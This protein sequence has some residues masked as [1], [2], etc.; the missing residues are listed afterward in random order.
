[1]PGNTTDKNRASYGQT[2]IIIPW[3]DFQSESKMLSLFYRIGL[4]GQYYVEDR[5][6]VCI[7]PI[8]IA[9]TKTSH[10]S[11]CTR[12]TKHH[13]ILGSSSLNCFSIRN[14][15]KHEAKGRLLFWHFKIPACL[16]FLKQPHIML[17]LENNLYKITGYIYYEVRKYSAACLIKHIPL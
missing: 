10:R 1:M 17:N 16:V 7:R 5:G 14:L 8:I 11:K 9:N 15:L 2:R 12:S 6:R 13:Q 4:T 3:L